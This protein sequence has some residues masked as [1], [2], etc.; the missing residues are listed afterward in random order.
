[1]HDRLLSKLPA[2]CLVYPAHDYQGRPCSTIGEEKRLNPRLTK[3]RDEFKAVMA[4]L[5]LPRPKQID[6][7]VPA[8]MRCGVF[9]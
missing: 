3:S 5:N 9:N 1:V 6:A 7:A 4:G 2:D 8:N